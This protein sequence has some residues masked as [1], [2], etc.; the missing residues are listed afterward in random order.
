SKRFY[1][2]QFLTRKAVNNDLLAQMEQILNDYFE[3]EESLSK[4]IPTVEYLAGK[5]L[6]SPRYLSDMLRSLTGQNAQQH[7]H[8]K[9]IEKAKEYLTTTSLSASEIAY[10][11]G[12]GHPQ[13]FS[14]L[15]R[16]KTNLTPIEYKQ[17]FN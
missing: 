3:K 6:L 16:K 5:L 15:F 1:H 17:S 7:I 4:G 8:E 10:I 11:L 14:K 2:R 12:F 13:S 9:M